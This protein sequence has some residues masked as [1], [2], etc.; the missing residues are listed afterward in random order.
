MKE[1]T[2]W[3]G[4]NKIAN[5]FTF[6][7]L[8]ENAINVKTIVNIVM[9]YVLNVING[10]QD[11]NINQ[12][13]MKRNEKKKERERDREEKNYTNC[14]VRKSGSLFKIEYPKR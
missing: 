5:T 7:I 6:F 13:M 9:I 8:L 10:R 12:F 4:I 2:M 14:A 11:L 3:F 1:N